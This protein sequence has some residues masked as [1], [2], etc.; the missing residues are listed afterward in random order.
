MVGLC[1]SGNEPPGS[2]KAN[3]REKLLP[4]LNLETESLKLSVYSVDEAFPGSWIGRTGRTRWPPRSP[5]LTPLDF[6]FWGF[7][8]DRVYAT[9]PRTIP[10]L[11]ERIE[12]TI[13]MVTPDMLTSPYR[14]DTSLTFVYSAELRTFENFA[15]YFVKN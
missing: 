2:L 11:V 12:R 15:P 3:K 5:D 6:F 13:Q 4:G 1:E 8:K 10:E 7:I 14:V 9:K